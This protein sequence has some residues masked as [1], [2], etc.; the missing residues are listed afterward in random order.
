MV[1]GITLLLT[2]LTGFSGL[3]YEVTWQKY[4]GTLLGSDSEATAAVL[5]LFLGGLSVG[6]S[7]FGRLTHR[8]VERARAAGS[9]PRLLTLYGGVEAAIGLYALVF[10]VVF[11]AVREFSFRLHGGATGAGFV[12]DVALAGLLIGPP[13]VLMGGTIPVLTQALARSLEDAT[14]VHAWVYAFN[15]AGAFVGALAAGFV[16][17][18]A[19]GLDGCMRAMGAVNLAAG[20]TF[21]VLGARAR[22]PSG[23]TSDR[24]ADAGFAAAAAPAGF[25]LYAGVALLA[26]FSMMSLQT[27]LNR[28]GG[29]TFGASQYTFAMVVAVFVFSIAVGSFAVSALRRIPPR[30]IVATQWLLVILLY[31]LY[32]L[33][34]DAGYWIYR[35]RL[36]FP[37]DEA[38]FS[39]FW[40]SAFGWMLAVVVVPIALSGAT[41]PLLF[42]HLRREVTNLG[43]IAGRLYSWN[44]LGSL[45]GALIGGYALLLV[46]DLHHVYR[47]ALGGLAIAAALLTVRLGVVRP[48]PAAGL[49]LAPVLA[50][51]VL[52]PPWRPDRMTA[53]LFRVNSDITRPGDDSDT[54][55]ER[56]HKRLEVLFHD[57]DP[58]ASIA[59]G[60]LNT[61]GFGM[62]TAINNNGKSDGNIPIDNPTMVLAAV[63]PALFAERNERAFVI[64][65]GT[66]MTVGE[67]AALP[68]MQQVDVA[69][70]SRAVI[71][72]APFFD[73]GNH[74]ASQSPKLRVL[75]GDAYRHLVRGDARYDVIASEPS[76]P[77]VTGVEMLFSRE[78]LE[79]AKRRLAPGG[80]WAQ[81]F[82][83]Y[84][85]D[86]ATVDLVLRTYTEV[87]DHVAVW[88]AMPPDLLLL[89]F[90]DDRHALDLERL[91]ARAS[92]PQFRL[93]LARARVHSFPAL[94]A[95]EL[96][97]IGVVHAARLEGPIHT[98]THPLLGHQAAR[99]F[100]ARGQG[101]LPGTFQAE[102]A[103]LGAERSLLRRYAARTGGRLEE[104]DRAEAVA[105]L[106]E[107]RYLECVAMLAEWQAEVPASPAREEVL[108]QLDREQPE[109]ARTIRAGLSGVAR[110]FVPPTAPLS[111]QEARALTN[112][113]TTYYHHAAP[114]PRS[115]IAA[116]WR[117]CEDSHDG[118]AASEGEGRCARNAV[119]AERWLGDAVAT[120]GG[121]AAPP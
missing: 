33:L 64:G 101:S 32:G 96:L 15:T 59:V 81:W 78:F 66:G 111:L 82:H 29:L 61:A 74:K 50:A 89:G 104:S 26:G 55:F 62:T 67:L 53:G 48:L 63:L 105:E 57:D 28:I 86:R 114:F 13:T 91:E 110:L 113:F 10:P 5:A 93:A 121:P 60:R 76:N 102:P 22:A 116:A 20:T 103:R 84:E 79:L 118:A 6:Y 31:F 56:F 36:G 34:E 51:L 19:L 98:L 92:L 3:V 73:Y 7:L 100:F 42:H 2:V 109:R 49:L 35:L 119:L 95:H 44:T 52:L 14:R 16:L 46:F 39:S 1:R 58:V 117:G 38:A 21:L 25:P 54:F 47:I 72:A 17:V 41:L 12:I 94:L 30:A 65:Y 40:A 88:F 97:P 23:S 107:G 90:D 112:T 8:V 80:V 24:D 37:N 69:E 68:D 9:P 87:F 27:V 43:A 83:L 75:Y 4:F 99:A 70:I 11:L 106:C 71:E 108:A 45:F 77:W 115:V 120:D 18:P 85:T